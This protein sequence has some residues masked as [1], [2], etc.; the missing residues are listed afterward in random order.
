MQIQLP[1]A[2]LKKKISAH[3][4]EL[5]YQPTLLETREEI[6]LL[7]LGPIMNIPDFNKSKIKKYKIQKYMCRFNFLAHTVE[8]NYQPTRLKVL[9]R[10]KRSPW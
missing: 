5:N 7:I 6:A 4:V 8:L 10:V 9:R 1:G 2:Q 3:T